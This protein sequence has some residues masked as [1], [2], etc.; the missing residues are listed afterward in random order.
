MEEQKSP[1]TPE[2]FVSELLPTF[3]KH[4]DRW[5]L[6]TFDSY[7]WK[8]YW[9]PLFDL[10]HFSPS[11]LLLQKDVRGLEGS[12]HMAYA[13]WNAMGRI[14]PN[15]MS[16]IEKPPGAMDWLNLEP[17]ILEELQDRF[18]RLLEQY[19]LSFS[20]AWE[21]TAWAP[22]DLKA[23]RMRPILVDTPDVIARKFCQDLGLVPIRD[24]GRRDRMGEDLMQAL[25]EEAISIAKE[26][27]DWTPN[28]HLELVIYETLLSMGSSE[29]LS[30]LE[31][32]KLRIPNHRARIVKPFASRLAFPFLLK[33]EIQL[34]LDN[35]SSPPEAAW[36]LIA[37][38][39]PGN[40]KPNSIRLK[41][42]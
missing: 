14:I 19:L 25:K 27:Q 35:P 29:G 15:D 30:D 28:E 7:S 20:N 21:E 40:L 32:E 5:P 2:E 10:K 42:K 12:I 8:F 24:G 16:D 31:L 11:Y 9:P 18:A 17:E 34:L 37:R 22:S 13:T 39:L 36:K 33:N 41:K 6:W 23:R 4:R 26:L 1:L 3:H 38:R